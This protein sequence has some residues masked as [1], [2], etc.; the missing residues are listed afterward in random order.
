MNSDIQKLIELVRIVKKPLDCLSGIPGSVKAAKADTY[1]PEKARKPFLQ[2]LGD[3]AAWLVKYQEANRFYTL[4]GLDL[5]G[6]DPSGYINYRTFAQQ[7]NDRNKTYAVGSQACILR[8]K[9]LF[10][11]FMQYN[12]IPVPEVFA[13]I[14]AGKVFNLHH[15]E[16]ELSALASLT[17]Y[18]VK[19]RDGECASFVKHIGTYDDLTALLPSLKSKYIVQQAI[20]QC[21]EMNALNPGAI[22]T[23]RIVTVSGKE[24]PAVLSSVLR[25]GSKRTGSVDNWAAGGL[26][27]GVE[28]DGRLKPWG[29]YKPGLGSKADRHPDTGIVF[30][31][32]TVPEY[33]EAAALCIR[34]HRL[35]DGIH[36]IGWDVAITADGP[37]RIEGNDNWEIT[38]MQAC[39]RPLKKDWEESL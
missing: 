29:Y 8:D 11:E 7:R 9:L 16:L 2:R 37:C 6:A 18:F 27:V 32:F 25:V 5:K 24:G 19:E 14:E 34:A 26:S 4:Y 21:A 3:N 31:D 15:E 17:D 22:N 38:L 10:Y 13:V 1:Y 30:S 28:S 23:L 36:S 12:G 35:L 20:R 33:N 39:D